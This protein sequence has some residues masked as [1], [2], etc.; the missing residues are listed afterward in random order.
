[1]NCCHAMLPS[2][3]AA[4]QGRIVT[5]VSDSGRIGEQRLTVYTAAKAAAGGFVGS[6]AKELG[7]YGVTC[8]AISLPTVEPPLEGEALAE[9]M[10]S[11]QV[12]AQLSHY[13]IRRFG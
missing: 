12:K 5:I 13:V 3:V 8:N 1:M 2:M 7:C 9:F 11:P 6:L 4:K 10:A